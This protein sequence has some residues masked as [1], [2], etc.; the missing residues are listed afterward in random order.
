MRLYFGYKIY[1]ISNRIVSLSV[2]LCLAKKL[3][4][5]LRAAEINDVGKMGGKLREKPFLL[6]ILLRF[7][8]KHSRSYALVHTHTH[9]HTLE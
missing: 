6:S 7:F 1:V 9:T 2:T 3:C 4:T 8:L 5:V